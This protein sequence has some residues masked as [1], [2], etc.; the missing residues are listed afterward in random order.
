[1]TDDDVLLYIHLTGEEVT[2][3]QIIKAIRE[4]EEVSLDQ[5]GEMCGGPFSGVLTSLVNKGMLTKR[6]FGGSYRYKLSPTAVKLVE[7]LLG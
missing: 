5:L 6:Y 7:K 1:M 2:Y 4:G 3:G